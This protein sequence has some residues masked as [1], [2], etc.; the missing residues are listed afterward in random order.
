LYNKKIPSSNFHIIQIVSFS[1]ELQYLFLSMLLL[2]DAWLVDLR[3]QFVFSNIIYGSIT[4]IHL[5][6]WFV[7]VFAVMRC[8]LF[9][10]NHIKQLILHFRIGSQ[11]Q[12]V[13]LLTRLSVLNTKKLC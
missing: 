9:G 13:Y 11:A 3:I 12:N 8:I 5:G 1:D 4:F 7:V 10:R 2:I 6:C